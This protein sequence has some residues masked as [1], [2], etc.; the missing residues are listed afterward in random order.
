MRSVRFC[1]SKVESLNLGQIV[2]K[3][4][5]IVPN[6]T[7]IKRL[8]PGPHAI[9]LW[10]HLKTGQQR[11]QGQPKDRVD[12]CEIDKPTPQLTAI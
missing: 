3:Q 6:A 9:E 1:K 7:G 4:Y 8:S 11:A 12:K 10:E 2:M 5:E